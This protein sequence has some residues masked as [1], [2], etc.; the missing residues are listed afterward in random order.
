ME[1]VTGVKEVLSRLFPDLKI[2]TTTALI[3][4]GILNS[5]SIISLVT[6][7]SKEY[8]IKVPPIEIVPENFNSIAAIEELCF[9]L[10]SR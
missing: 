6:E 5:F 9:R 2:E 8:Q 1:T 7:L 4:D 10:K 3:D